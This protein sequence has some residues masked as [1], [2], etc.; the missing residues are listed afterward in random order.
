[1][2]M[3]NRRRSGG[4]ALVEYVILLG[5]ISVVSIGAVYTL[6]ARV[7]EVFYETTNTLEEAEDVVSVNIDTWPGPAEPEYTFYFDGTSENLPPYVT[8]SGNDYYIDLSEIMPD[9]ST[10]ATPLKFDAVISHSGSFTKKDADAHD[11]TSSLTVAG[12][13]YWIREDNSD[14][15]IVG[16]TKQGSPSGTVTASGERASTAVPDDVGQIRLAPR[17]HCNPGSVC[18]RGAFFFDIN[19][20]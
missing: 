6:G 11:S 1:M 12:T 5:L 2:K 7:T 3:V 4:A 18:E 9:P 8:K 20:H 13:A 16:A 17:F 15:Y 14:L 19:F 10:W